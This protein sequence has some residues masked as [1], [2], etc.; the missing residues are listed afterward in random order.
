MK[1]I[2]EIQKMLDDKVNVMLAAHGGRVDIV[3]IDREPKDMQMHIHV[4]RVKMSGGCRGCASA[5]YT[6]NL[7][8][9]N[10][11]KE[12]DPTIDTVVDVTDH[13]DKSAAFYKE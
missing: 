6:L 11:I 12:F 5:R 8:V 9:S 13:T 4:A 3:D 1:T 2:E 10:A 7:M